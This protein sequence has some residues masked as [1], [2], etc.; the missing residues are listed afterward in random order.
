VPLTSER[1]CVRGCKTRGAHYG[2]CPW[3]GVD[4][5]SIAERLALPGA[6]R[7]CTGCA[8]A[9]TAAESAVCDRCARGFRRMLVDGP[10]LLG[11]LRSLAD[12]RSALVYE[13]AA[14]RGGST[15][16]EAPAP[17]PADLLDA[18]VAL[19]R[20]F[21]VTSSD[22]AEAF[23]QARYGANVILHDLDTG[24]LNDHAWVLALAGQVLDRHEPD[25][26]GVRDAWS[27]A[28]AHARWGVVRRERP[29]LVVASPSPALRPVPEYDEDTASP[30][31]EW[32]AESLIVRDQAAQLAGSLR[33]LQRWE[34]AGEIAP[35]GAI[36]TAGKRTT[37]YRRATVIAVREQMKERAGRGLSEPT[38]EAA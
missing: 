35:E 10:D 13:D 38:A 8:G 22:A 16:T 4:D 37:I 27:V 7:E 30:V 31:T 17:V 28:D 18:I 21:L 26:D 11:R 34:K 20:L 29:T 15:S 19:E 1:E 9:P 36:W 14:Q 12:P 2:A 33:T 3:Y 23:E 6:P 25:G 24:L 32:G 5:A